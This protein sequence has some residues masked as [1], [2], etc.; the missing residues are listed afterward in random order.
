VVRA[1]KLKGLNRDRHGRTRGNLEN[2]GSR[3]LCGTHSRHLGTGTSRREGRLMRR[4]IVLLWIVGFFGFVAAADAQTPS[5]TAGAPFD[6]TYR[7]VSSAKVNKL[8]TTKKG[9]TAQCPDRI[10]GPLT[11]V[12]GQA[13]YSSAT[14]YRLRG[15]VGPQGELAMRA[16]GPGGSRP[17]E[18]NFNGSIDNA[19]TA[20]G[21]QISNACNYDFIWQK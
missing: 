16:A 9:Q 10:P 13:R 15:R 3:P 6:G 14:G 18:I 19:G 17:I 11:I 1:L 20:R 8:Y 5:P 21:R 7:F 2:S 12:R 4:Q